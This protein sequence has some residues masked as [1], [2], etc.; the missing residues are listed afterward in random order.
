MG[1][2]ADIVATIKNYFPL[3]YVVVCSPTHSL[4]L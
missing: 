1:F 4:S 3:A 2:S